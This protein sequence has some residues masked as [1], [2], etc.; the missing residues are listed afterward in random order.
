[1]FEE[2][3]RTKQELRKKRTFLLSGLQQRQSPQSNESLS[4]QAPEERKAKQSVPKKMKK[5]APTIESTPVNQVSQLSTESPSF[6]FGQMNLA[7]NPEFLHPAVLHQAHH[8]ASLYPPQQHE[9][10]GNI[11]RFLQVST[12][13]IVGG[14]GDLPM[15]SQLFEGISQ[16]SA[17]GLRFDFV[18]PQLSQEEVLVYTPSLSLVKFRFQ[19]HLNLPKVQ[20]ETSKDSIFSPLTPSAVLRTKLPEATLQ[21]F[22]RTSMAALD[23]ERSYFAL[24]WQYQMSL[25]SKICS[26]T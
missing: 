18:E 3:R 8:L 1:M 2:R 25:T 12:P 24:K 9:L 13:L 20:F 17:K 4:D 14:S 21:L 23:T 10:A 26:K 6:L 15:I 22:E 16:T 19:D 11:Q 7:A 5:P